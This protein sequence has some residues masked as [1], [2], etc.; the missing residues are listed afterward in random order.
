MVSRLILGTDFDFMLFFSI[1]SPIDHAC[2][3]C[4][5]FLVVV[6]VF[7]GAVAFNADISKWDISKATNLMSSESTSVP[8]LFKDGISR[9]FLMTFFLCF[10][11]S[12]V[13]SPFLVV[14]FQGAVAFNAD[15]SKWEMSQVN[16]MQN[17]TSTLVP[18]LFMEG[19]SR[20]F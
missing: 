5:P 17:S 15:L 2:L 12:I 20:F 11:I 13:L 8:Y 14:V 9:F 4:C 10:F 7:E 18:H 1:L 3:L 19:I 16:L 6:I